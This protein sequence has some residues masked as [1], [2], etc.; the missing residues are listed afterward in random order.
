MCKICVR[1]LLWVAAEN[2]S[3]EISHPFSSI[4]GDSYTVSAEP[5]VLAKQLCVV[6]PSAGEGQESVGECLST[7]PLFHKFF[8]CQHSERQL[9]GS[10]QV[11][12]HRPMSTGRFAAQS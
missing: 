1:A 4:T 6:V 12:D 3:T 10:V 8:M 11:Y 9:L 5:E 7:N 2:L